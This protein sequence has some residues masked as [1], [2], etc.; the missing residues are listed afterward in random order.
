MK[1]RSV[2]IAAKSQKSK[3]HETA[4]ITPSMR[5]RRCGISA[6]RGG[7]G[8]AGALAS[9][10]RSTCLQLAYALSRCAL[11]RAHRALLRALAATLARNASIGKQL[12]RQGGSASVASARRISGMARSAGAPRWRQRRM[13]AAWRR[14]SRINGKQRNGGVKRKN[15]AEKR[16]RH[17][18]DSGM[19]S[20]KAKRA[21]AAWRSA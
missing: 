15:G 4:S 16:R 13:T 5:S 17:Q 7:A 18:R 6:H 19:A 2:S 12:A 11:Q 20:A 9:V 10:A 1:K 21:Q 3:K 14:S 8:I